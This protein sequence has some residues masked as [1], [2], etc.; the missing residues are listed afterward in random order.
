MNIPFVDLKAQYKSIQQEIDSAISE[1]VSTTAFIGGKFH[2]VFE[3]DFARFC[4]MKHCIGVGN[5]TDAL[6]LALKALGIGPGDEVITAANSFIA[7]SEAVTMTGARVVFVDINPLTYTI[8]TDKIEEK[9][10]PRTKA[11]LPVDLYG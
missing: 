5:G 3:Q 9:I 1:V 10:T 8:D 7:T 6:F 4:E 11:I 2:D